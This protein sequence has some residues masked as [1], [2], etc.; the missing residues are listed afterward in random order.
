MIK[1]IKVIEV[2]NSDIIKNCSIQSNSS[3][4]FL[5]TAIGVALFFIIVLVIC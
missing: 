2:K 5:N 4:R 1:A 3:K